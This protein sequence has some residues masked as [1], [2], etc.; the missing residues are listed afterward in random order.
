MQVSSTTNWGYHQST[1]ASIEKQFIHRETRVL[2]SVL[3][4]MACHFTRREATSGSQAASGAVSYSAHE[5]ILQWP[6]SV[7]SLVVAWLIVLIHLL[8]RFTS[9]SCQSVISLCSLLSMKPTLLPRAVKLKEKLSSNCC[10]SRLR[11]ETWKHIPFSAVPAS[12]QS[13]WWTTVMTRRRR[14][15]IHKVL[16]L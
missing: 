4:Q 13:C 6:S 10:N 8:G 9:V 14:R 3:P 1:G 2:L 12:L 16:K 11:S 15:R 7:Y 5:S